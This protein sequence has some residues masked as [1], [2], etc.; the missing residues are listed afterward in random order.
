VKDSHKYHPDLLNTN[1]RQNA[2]NQN[3]QREIKIAEFMGLEG[4]A[5]NRKQDIIFAILK[6]HAMNGEGITCTQVKASDL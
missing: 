3:H 1:L 5:R 6:R 4:M 2:K